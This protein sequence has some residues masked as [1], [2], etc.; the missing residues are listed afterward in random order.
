MSEIT[1]KYSLTV[2]DL[3]HF[4]DTVL[5]KKT[6]MIR[7]VCLVITFVWAF[8]FIFEENYRA[9]PVALIFLVLGVIYP[10]LLKSENRKVYKDYHLLGKEIQLEFYND[11]IVEK[12]L[13]AH[14][15]DYESEL[16]VPFEAIVNITETDE[17]FLFFISPINA[18][19]VPKEV[20]TKEDRIKLFHLIENVF[21][22]RFTRTN[23]RRAMKNDKDKKDGT[24]GENK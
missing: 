14:E 17:I 8:F 7:A 11:H 20:F 2:D 1:L 6:V 16:H 3:V 18:I 5:Q 4:N 21:S 9:L 24:D 22:D 13:P 15:G 10:Y 12:V 19:G 23:L